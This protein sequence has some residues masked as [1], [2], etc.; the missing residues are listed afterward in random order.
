MPPP[1]PPPPLDIL[2]YSLNRINSIWLLL[3]HSTRGKNHYPKLFWESSHQRDKI[4]PYQRVS[5]AANQHST[6]KAGTFDWPYEHIHLSL[7]FI[8]LTWKRKLRLNLCETARLRLHLRVFRILRILPLHYGLRWSV[9]KPTLWKTGTCLFGSQ[10]KLTINRKLRN[11][12]KYCPFPFRC[13]WMHE[14]CKGFETDD[15][16]MLC[17]RLSGQLQFYDKLLGEVRGYPP[18]HALFRRC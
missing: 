7:L 13:S 3:I 11:R 2:Q 4:S 8:K 12:R 18:S 16:L 5:D 10:P 6:V 17:A 9:L 1:P 14:M 15:N